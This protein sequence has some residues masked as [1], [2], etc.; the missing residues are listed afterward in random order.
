MPR[1]LTCS[2]CPGAHVAVTLASP[3]LLLSVVSYC[4]AVKGNV[5]DQARV[6]AAGRD[7]R[8]SAAA[9]SEEGRQAALGIVEAVPGTRLVEDNTRLIPEAKPFVWAGER[10]VTHF[11]LSGNVPSPAIR[12]R[13]D[14][15]LR[16]LAGG[17]EVADRMEYARGAPVRFD[18]AAQLLIEQ[19]ARLSGGKVALSDSAVSLKGTARDLGGREAIADALK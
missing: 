16:G 15:A 4:A 3:R 9:F 1:A 6:E 8:F 13:L 12:G 5:L 11:T 17:T 14:D 7:L 19:L 2:V 18:A 10:D